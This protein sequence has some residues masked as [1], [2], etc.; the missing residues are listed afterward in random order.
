MR[1]WHELRYSLQIKLHPDHRNFCS[2]SC[3]KSGNYRTL[4]VTTQSQVVHWCIQVIEDR[5]LK[6][7]LD[8]H[9]LRF[10]TKNLLLSTLWHITSTQ[11]MNV[12]NWRRNESLK[13]LYPSKLFSLRVRRTT[14][15]WRTGEILTLVRSFVIKVTRTT[16]TPCL[17][18]PSSSSA[19]AFYWWIWAWWVLQ[20]FR[21]LSGSHQTRLQ[22]RVS[23][24]HCPAEWTTR[25]D[26]SSGHETTSV[27]DWTETWKD[28][29]GNKVDD[30]TDERL[31]SQ[32]IEKQTVEHD[33]EIS[34]QIQIKQSK[35]TFSRSTQV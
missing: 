33:L 8:F 21:S 16:S 6:V 28:L 11:E 12:W 24:W 10:H 32:S 14:F 4:R 1:G 26:L 22:R 3:E 19:S 18:A 25:L 20:L 7:L 31:F 35:S 30:A 29:K 5:Q 17:P 23:M 2:N 27:W 13:Y 15:I 9:S 34:L